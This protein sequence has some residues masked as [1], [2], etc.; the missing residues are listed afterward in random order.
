GEKHKA[1]FEKVIQNYS[2]HRGFEYDVVYRM[3]YFDDDSFTSLN[4]KVNLIMNAD[5]I[6]GCHFFYEYAREGGLI[7]KYC[8]GKYLYVID[9]SQKQYTRFSPHDKETSP[10]TGAT[11]GMI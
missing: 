6:F 3:K 4:Y 7:Y 11:D 10:I 5:S 2:D 9:S 8:N 1:V